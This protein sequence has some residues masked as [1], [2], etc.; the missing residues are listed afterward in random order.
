MEKL[1]HKVTK[2]EMA[3]ADKNSQEATAGT[4][5]W[6]IQCQ[7]RYPNRKVRGRGCWHKRPGEEYKLIPL[8][9]VKHIIKCFFLSSKLDKINHY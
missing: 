6:Q 2:H 8:L 4:S 9:E 3:T 1:D 5:C 7:T